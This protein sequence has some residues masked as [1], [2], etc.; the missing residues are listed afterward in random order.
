MGVAVSTLIDSAKQK[1]DDAE[2]KNMAFID[3]VIENLEN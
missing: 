3:S 1:K 2:I